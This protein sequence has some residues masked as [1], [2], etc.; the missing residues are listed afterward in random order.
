MS[1]WALVAAVAERIA[2]G[3]ITPL[4]VL[5]LTCLAAGCVLFHSSK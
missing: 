2:D 3:L 5:A 1:G 4:T